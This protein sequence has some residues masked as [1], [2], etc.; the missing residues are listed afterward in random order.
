[1]ATKGST[2]ASRTAEIDSA[3]TRKLGE[4]AKKPVLKA[5]FRTDRATAQTFWLDSKSRPN[6]IGI[7]ETGRIP[8]ETH[9]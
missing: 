8:P 2:P 6:Q 1:M 3:T 4:G 7:F 5:D 9:D